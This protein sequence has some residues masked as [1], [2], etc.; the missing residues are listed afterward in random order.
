MR[1]LWRTADAG[2]SDCD[3]VQPHLER[4]GAALVLV[5]ADLDVLEYGRLPDAAR[6]LLA[7]DALAVLLHD[8]ADGLTVE[9]VVQLVLAAVELPLDAD[10][11]LEGDGGV[12][13][14]GT[15]HQHRTILEVAKDVGAHDVAEHRAPAVFPDLGRL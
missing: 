9:P 10:P 1:S 6:P 14:L 2:A 11:P 15:V 12:H 4:D 13:A 3:I 5:E 8:V 7:A